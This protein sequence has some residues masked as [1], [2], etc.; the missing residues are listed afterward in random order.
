MPR[1]RCGVHTW[2]RVRFRPEA[3]CFAKWGAAASLEGQPTPSSTATVPLED[4][5]IVLELAQSYCVLAQK[6]MMCVSI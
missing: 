5:Q 1:C 4:V 2:L 6:S 3:A